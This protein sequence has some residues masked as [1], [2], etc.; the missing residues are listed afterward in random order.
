MAEHDSARVVRLKDRL[1]AELAKAEALLA[2]DPDE[3]V[4]AQ[5]EVRAATLRL[6]RCAVRDRDVSART[7]GDCDGC[8]DAVVRDVLKTMAEQR[9]VS[10]QEFEDAGR[11][12][13]AERER[14]ELAVIEEFLPKPLA[15]EALETAVRTVVDDLEASTLKDLGKCMSALKA[16]YPGVIDSKAAGKAVRRALQ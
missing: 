5:L 12:E 8:Q 16:R 15:D 6:V 3:T 7:R 13:D 10:S 14:A 9:R 4:N 11:I 1:V 2:K